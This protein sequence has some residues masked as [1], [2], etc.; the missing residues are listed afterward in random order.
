MRVAT[1]V[2]PKKGVKPAPASV[3]KHSDA[4][5]KKMYE[6]LN[7]M[8]KSTE[9]S[10]AGY[11][12]S[13]QETSDQPNEEGVHLLKEELETLLSRDLNRM[14]DIKAAIFRIQNGTYGICELTGMLISTD[15]L[16]ALPTATT[17]IV[18]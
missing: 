10:A 17:N 16:K 18:R 2:S 11:R 5:L 8:L 15:R 3:T 7:S 6:T 4:F 12:N 14:G 1:A 9:A 13:L